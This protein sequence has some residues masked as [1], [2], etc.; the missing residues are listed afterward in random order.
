[1]KYSKVHYALLIATLLM[2]GVFFLSV[3]QPVSA[4][5]VQPTPVP[6]ATDPAIPTLQAVVATQQVQI[7]QLQ[8]DLQYETQNRQFDTR[9]IKWT[10]GIAVLIATLVIGFL[11]WLGI[12][13]FKDLQE[14]WNRKSQK[15][16]DQALYKFDPSNLPIQLPNSAV[17]IHRLLSLRQLGKIEFYDDYENLKDNKL[18][19]IIVISMLDKDQL[20]DD[21]ARYQK[22]IQSRKLD[23]STTGIILYAGTNKVS[24]DTQTAFDNMVTANYP[25]TVVSNILVVGRGLKIDEPQTTD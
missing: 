18:Q 20:A 10:W 2:G 14:Q 16:L 11:S 21:E 5:T 4:Q 9:D 7:N 1:M 8:R 15:L 17:K 19:G 3:L 25:A 12:Q 13:N 24:E 6:N 22:F 23:S